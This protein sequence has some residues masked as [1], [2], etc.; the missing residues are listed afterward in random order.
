MHE[1]MEEETLRCR[2]NP[3]LTSFGI[4]GATRSFRS[5]TARMDQKIVVRPVKILEI[6]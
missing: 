2:T 4:R 6:P 3:Y 5:A 1:S